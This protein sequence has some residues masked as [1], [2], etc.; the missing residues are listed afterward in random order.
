MGSAQPIPRV[1]EDYG[2]VVYQPDRFLSFLDSSM[3]T[4]PEGRVH[5]ELTVQIL[6]QIRDNMALINRKQDQIGTDVHVVSE[7]VARLEERNERFA[8]LESAI[9]RDA[10]RID[11]LMRDKDRRDGA[12]GLATWFWKNWPFAGIATALAAVVAWAN[13][14]L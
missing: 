11:A 3:S 13:G 5:A 2:R 14:K 12:T 8:R 6:T 9:E 10:G 7:R 4:D 1:Q